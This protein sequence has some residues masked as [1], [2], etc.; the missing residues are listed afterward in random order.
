MGPPGALGLALFFPMEGDA[1]PSAPVKGFGP[2]GG[3]HYSPSV[4]A[5]DLTLSRHCS[6]NFSIFGVLGPS[7]S[8]SSAIWGCHPA[9]PCVG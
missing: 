9:L 3:G 6:A 4:A 5:K 1:G 7:P 2:P 8:P